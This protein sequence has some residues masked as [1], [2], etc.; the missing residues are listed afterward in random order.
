[1]NYKKIIR[2]QQ[3]RFK[4]LRMLNWVPDSVMLR[5][6]YRVKMGFWPNLKRP[7]RYTEK[8]QL[9][10]MRYRNPVMTQ[11]VDKFEVRKYVESKGLGHI[12]NDIYGVYDSVYVFDFTSLPDKFVVK[13]TTGGGGLNVIVVKDKKQCNF[14]DIKRK[15]ATWEK[16]K[17]GSIS[18][19]REWA[20]NN[21]RDTR[22]IIEK[23][24][25]DSTG[26]GD[27]SDY[28][29][30]FF[31]GRFKLLW[32]DKNRYTDHHRGFY[33]ENLDFMPNKSWIYN[34]F[35]TPPKLPPV[36]TDMIKYGSILSEEF[37]HARVDFYCV[38]NKVYFGEI[39]FYAN[40]GYGKFTPDDFDFELGSYF[41]EY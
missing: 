39:T 5:I 41:T 30:F 4:I 33:D 27:L 34:T 26:S 2:S 38:N 29:L 10:K 36:I 13:S 37:P 12:L 15:I 40:C 25:E 21:M 20:Y 8:L 18:A 17:Q 1:M 7:K 35:K 11:C 16:H 9:Y 14:E 31:N 28:K 22:I 6:Q 24:L 23:F 19:G 32:V 3:L